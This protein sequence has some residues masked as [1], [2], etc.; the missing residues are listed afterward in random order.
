MRSSRPLLSLTPKIV[1]SFP[2]CC[3]GIQK[4]RGGDPDPFFHHRS[5]PVPDSA[6]SG[7]STS[8]E[9][10]LPSLLT[11]INR[12]PSVHGSQ[13]SPVLGDAVRCENEQAPFRPRDGFLGRKT[14]R[15][16]RNNE[17]GKYQITVSVPRSTFRTKSHVTA[18]KRE[19]RGGERAGRGLF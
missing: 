16:S 12:P 10:R 8:Q 15:T 6:C 19:R 18:M 17:H 14:K 9:G 13:M 1:F 4:P 7:S 11:E 5:Q 2:S 3:A